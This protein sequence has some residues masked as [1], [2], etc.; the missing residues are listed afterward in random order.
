MAQACSACAGLHQVHKAHQVTV[1]VRHRVLQGITHRRL[2]P[3]GYD[4]FRLRVRNETA[5][6][7]PIGKVQLL[8][9]EFWHLLKL[10]QAGFLQ[11]HIIVVI[12]IIDPEYLATFVQQTLREV[13]ANK[14]GRPCNQNP[15]SYTTSLVLIRTCSPPA[16]R[17]ELRSRDDAPK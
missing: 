17:E 4:G 13:K 14:A 12:K 1:D 8:K 15:H 9:N 7:S 5:E 3:E 2:G 11:I 6:I 16:I 10:H